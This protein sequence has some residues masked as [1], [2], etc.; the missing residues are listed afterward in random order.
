MMQ[1][2]EA[3]HAGLF[4][5]TGPAKPDYYEKK[6]QRT[7]SEW[8][9]FVN[10]NRSI[11]GTVVP[12]EVQESWT[13]CLSLGID[14]M[15]EPR[16]RILSGRDLQGLLEENRHFIS[17]SRV[18]MKHLYQFM[19]SS[20]FIV[21]LFDHRGYL[22][23]IMTREEYR[24]G[25]RKRN[26][27]VGALWD[28]PTAGNN[29]V[30][31]V[32]AQRKPI[33]IF[34]PQ[35]F[36]KTYHRDTVASAPIYSPEG[37]LIGGVTLTGYYYGTNP[38]ILGLAVAS[39]KAIENQLH[40]QKALT[41]AQ[42]A[43]S[44]QK[45]VIASIPEALI[46]VDNGGYISLLNSN[47]R[48]MFHLDGRRVEGEHISRV[49]GADNRPF[50][51]IIKGNEAVTDMEI[52]IFAAYSAHD[53]TLTCNPIYSP[54]EEILGKIIILNEI[55]RAK[56]LVTRM[57]GAKAN[58]HFKDICGRNPKFLKTIE[59]ARM[60]A[61]STSNALLL[62]KSGTGKDIFAQS[63]HN[64]SSRKSGPYL[65][66]NCAAIPRD[67]IT[68][69]LFGYS[70]G[71]F[72]GSRRGGSQGKFELADGG[73]I[74]LDEIAETPLELQAV[75]LRVI[76]DK[77]IIRI[78]GKRVR[79]VNVRVIAATN[80]DLREE[81]RRGN[82]REDLYYRLNVFTIHLIPLRER[83]DDIP[84][85]L[86]VFLEKYGKLLGKKVDRVDPGILDVFSRYA[87]PG[88]VRELQNI[89]ERMMNFTRKTDLTMDLIPP[90][91]LEGGDVDTLTAACYPAGEGESGRSGHRR[92][93]DI[94]RDEFDRDND[95]EM[96]IRM[97]G[98]GV[99]KKR[100]AETLNL[101]R[102]TIY[103]R[104]KKY[105]IPYKQD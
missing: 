99:T 70:D 96:I 2:G 87:W 89:V 78:G 41:K 1:S 61:E 38:H 40:I 93:R 48:R 43:S 11:D 81:V 17:I 101:S 31:T 77:S 29:A 7:V 85:L 75:L 102:M 44:Y 90:E 94:L 12:R 3:V 63:I 34:G 80:K 10:G 55:K 15:E 47:A 42:I 51:D 69:E 98:L 35:H 100:I 105:N 84:I 83:R 28:E 97:V 103:R 64:A 49:F 71:S 32:L 82:F 6:Y 76:E 4:D 20:R 23:E 24:E 54:Q 46:T 9:K 45:T 91:I 5:R 52:R 79:P 60:V 65:A 18:F 67:L 26:W 13:R 57:I 104:L 66:I 58:F 14:P 50:L 37:T 88:N 27:L 53:Y 68:S 8:E 33:R 59:Q 86:D 21:T 62:G 30:G 22:L 74:F 72:T 56:T 39:A 16:H 95:R 73:T 36:N 25:N 19:K 92:S